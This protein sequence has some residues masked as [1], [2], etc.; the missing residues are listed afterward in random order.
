MD[1]PSIPEVLTSNPDP[2]VQMLTWVVAAETV[3]IIAVLGA[4]ATTVKWML[5]RCDNR[6]DAAWRKVSDLTGAINQLNSL[7][8]D[9]QR[10]MPIRSGVTG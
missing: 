4:V 9:R 6:N 1:I 8:Q 5:L 10:R 2:L 3:A 7:D